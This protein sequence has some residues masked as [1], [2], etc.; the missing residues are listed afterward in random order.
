MVNQFAS[1]ASPARSTHPPS[2]PTERASPTHSCRSAKISSRGTRGQCPSQEASQPCSSATRRALAGSV[3]MSSCTPKSGTACTWVWSLPMTVAVGSARCIFRS[4]SAPWRTTPISRRIGV[5][6]Y[7]SR[8]TAPESGNAAASFRSPAG[9][10]ARRSGPPATVSRPRGHPMANG[11]TSPQTSA[12]TR[13]S[14][15]NASATATRNRSP[16]ARRKNKALP[17]RPMVI[18]S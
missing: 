6:C 13:I 16:S 8:W 17:C 12:A 10:P 1:P 15:A 11:C 18:R 5:P 9:R 2:R 7:W 3:R 4:T 14:G